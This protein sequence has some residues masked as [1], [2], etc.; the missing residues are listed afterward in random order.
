MS[1]P[2]PEWG[3]EKVPLTPEEYEALIESAMTMRRVAQSAGLAAESFLL[4]AKTIVDSERM[5]YNRQERRQ[6]T[7][8]H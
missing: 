5:F 1:E 4:L 6:L 2:K 3:T 8:S 7:K